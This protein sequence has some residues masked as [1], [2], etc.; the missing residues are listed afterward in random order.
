M[1]DRRAEVFVL[2]LANSDTEPAG[3]WHG[4]IEHVSSGRAATFGSLRELVTFVAEFR[5]PP[6][7]RTPPPE[8]GE[9]FAHG[10]REPPA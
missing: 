5:Q 6:P 1:G 3:G 8:P 2:R 7:L 4:R 10:L 9:T